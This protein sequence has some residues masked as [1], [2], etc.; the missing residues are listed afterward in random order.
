MGKDFA[1]GAQ[2]FYGRVAGPVDRFTYWLFGLQLAY[3]PPAPTSCA[4]ISAA[5]GRRA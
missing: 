2:F 1:I 3:C 5:G 4:A